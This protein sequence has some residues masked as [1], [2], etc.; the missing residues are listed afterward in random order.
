MAQ[1]QDLTDSERLELKYVNILNEKIEEIRYIVGELDTQITRGHALIKDFGTALKDANDA[2]K[3][4]SKTEVQ[5]HLAKEAQKE[6][7][8]IREEMKKDKQAGR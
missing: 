4:L 8:R 6:A 3:R 5:R 7:D 1:D 2:I